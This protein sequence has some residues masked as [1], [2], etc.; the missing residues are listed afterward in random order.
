MSANAA[1]MAS[2]FYLDSM[3]IYRNDERD[4]DAQGNIQGVRLV[5]SSVACNKHD[6]DN[7]DVVK[8]PAGQSKDSNIFTMDKVSL[9]VSV[10]LRS[11]D[12]VY[13]TT[14]DGRSEWFNVHGAPKH[15]T[16]LGYQ[17]AYLTTTTKPKV[18]TGTWNG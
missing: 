12:L 13:I 9:A 11:E 16:L 3:D 14:R 5:I 18:H 6:T 1:L 4:T 10:D 17:R 8:S 7:S 15:R 2:T